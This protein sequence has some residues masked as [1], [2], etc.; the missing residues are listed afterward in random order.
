MWF[1]VACRA[2][3][4]P[5]QD[6]FR[7]MASLPHCAQGLGA[8]QGAA[9]GCRAAGAT[10]SA[11]RLS[12]HHSQQTAGSEKR[13]GKSLRL[14]AHPRAGSL[15]LPQGLATVI[16]GGPR[17]GA[18]NPPGSMAEARVTCCVRG[19]LHLLGGELCGRLLAA[20]A[21]LGPWA[22]AACCGQLPTFACSPPEECAQE[23]GGAGKRLF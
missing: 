1:F 6:V 16:A 23:V 22:Q 4:R 9:Q 18:I 11:R 19:I 14:Q 13:C 8:E 21:A 5:A 17:A 15:Q 20:A 7:K 2:D 12:Q 10:H 3:P